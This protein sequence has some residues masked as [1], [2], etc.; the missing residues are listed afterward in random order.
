[1]KE[2]FKILACKFLNRLNNKSLILFKL[3][4]SKQNQ[5][6]MTTSKISEAKIIHG[7]QYLYFCSKTDRLTDQVNCMQTACVSLSLSS[8]K[9]T[10]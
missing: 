1:M 9:S 3:L 7:F 8:G 2:T 6:R 10:F 4:L 5:T